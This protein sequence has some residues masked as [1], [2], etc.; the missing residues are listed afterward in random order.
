[1]A[2][3]PKDEL[4]ITLP[5]NSHTRLYPKNN[6]SRYVVELPAPVHLE[7][8]WEVAI[9]DIR[10]PQFYNNIPSEIPVIFVIHPPNADF[11]T[12]NPLTE[13]PLERKSQESSKWGA[14]AKYVKDIIKDDEYNIFANGAKFRIGYIDPGH[15]KTSALAGEMFEHLFYKLFANWKPLT[16]R[17]KFEAGDQIGLHFKV[18]SSNKSYTF[19]VE[20]MTVSIL[21]KPGLLG[22]VLNFET[23]SFT[24]TS[25]QN[26]LVWFSHDNLT[27]PT[28][29]MS[30]HF[31]LISSMYIYSD[32]TEY[33]IVGDTL[34]PILGIVPIPA[35]GKALPYWSFNPPYYFT[36]KKK[37][38]NSV[39]IQLNTETGLKFPFIGTGNAEVRLHFRKKQRLF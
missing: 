30:E 38:F 10:Y 32:L 5:S 9:I 31:S 8:D 13:Y 28:Y 16:D 17:N 1:M 2:I 15:V 25:Q 33:Q 36:V 26:P 27:S 39:E 22:D 6:H 23:K 11:F 24:K 3:T 20:G 35:D 18:D 7:G 19:Q 34:V 37:D 21:T 14:A 4:Q 12:N 29:P